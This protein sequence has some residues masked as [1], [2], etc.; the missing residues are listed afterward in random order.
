MR[1]SILILV[2]FS[3][4]LPVF[5]QSY[6]DKLVVVKLLEGHWKGDLNYLNFQDDKTRGTVDLEIQGVRSD[7]EVELKYTYYNNGEVVREGKDKVVADRNESKFDF[8]DVWDLES[9]GETG[10]G[11]YKIVLVTK[12]KDNNKRAQMRKTISI[13]DSRLIIKRD[14]K[15]LKQESDYFN[16]HIYSLEKQ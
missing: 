14:I 8:N 7:N 16:R 11:T 6:E 2:L 9:F 15:Y 10:G 3:A 1:K 13:S 12:G 5:A 4:N